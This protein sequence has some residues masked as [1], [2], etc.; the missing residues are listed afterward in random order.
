[1]N[2]SDWI[3]DDQTD[4]YMSGTFRWKT[5]KKL[6][7]LLKRTTPSHE[8]NDLTEGWVPY[9]LSRFSDENDGMRMMQ[10]AH[11]KFQLQYIDMNIYYIYN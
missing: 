11:G 6:P 10:L 1:M 9:F 3:D 4:G 7:N 2:P 5:T 8:M